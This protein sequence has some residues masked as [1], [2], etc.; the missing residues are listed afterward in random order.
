MVKEIKVK[1]GQSVKKGDV[2][3]IIKN[4]PSA[5]LSESAKNIYELAQKNASENAPTLLA[6]KNEVFASK[7]K[8][9]LDSV[10]AQRYAALLKENATSQLT[11]DQ[12]QTQF[13]VSKRN[14][15]KSLNSYLSTRDR[16]K[17]EAENAS[18]QLQNTESNKSEYTI[19]S[20]SDG[21]VFD[22]DLSLNE[23]VPLNKHV[24]EI[25]NPNDFEVE[26][27]IDETDVNLMKQNQEVLFT[28]DAFK[29]SVFSG[30]VVE[31]YPR[32]SQGAKTC[33]VISTFVA[34]K[35][36]NPFSGMSVEANIIIAKKDSAIVIPR[37]YLWEGNKVK[38]KGDEN[39][40]PIKKGIEDLEYV[41]I[42]NGINQNDELV[43]K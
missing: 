34:S 20:E 33:K 19:L 42:I 29:D 37:E 32:I 40:I 12:A 27:N 7:S 13:E 8:Y 2:L 31:I 18:L 28:C 11:Y 43:K 1:I 4:D 21:V 38:R 23:L 36:L 10:N 9:E 6:L 39:L 15:F 3:A 16:L 41:E 30:N 24:F 5:I 26:L 17:T 35:N 22:L 25:G 14:Y